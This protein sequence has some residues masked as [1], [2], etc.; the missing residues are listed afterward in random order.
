MKSPLQIRDV[1]ASSSERARGFVTIAESATG[2][3]TMPLM[4]INGYEDGPVLCLTAGVHATEYAPIDA[5]MRL[6]HE[7]RPETLKG[8]VIAVPVVSMTMFERRMGFVSPVDGLNL[9]K[10]APGR[11]DGTFSE[12][13]AHVLLEEIIGAADC[14]IDLHAGDLG[15]DLLA[16]AGSAMSG[17]PAVDARGEAMARAFTPGLISLSTSPDT[18]IPPFPGSLCYEAARRG[19][20]SILAESGGDGTLR[21]EDVRV[22]VDGALAVMRCLGMIDGTPQPVRR[23]VAARH[24]VIVRASRAGM[25]RHKVRVGDH[26]TDGQIVAEIVDVFGEVVEHVPSSGA[27]I[28]GLIWTSKVVATG[29]P[30]VRYW[31]TDPA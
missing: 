26:V 29:D 6:L 2:P 13:L 11:P 4:I 24:R 5:C 15:E 1:R 17:D 16:F 9:N 28:I 12:R 25:V 7:L 19:I 31:I 30:L 20:A 27:G 18:T 22:H 10:V 8:A 3:L 14:H 23:R 21:E